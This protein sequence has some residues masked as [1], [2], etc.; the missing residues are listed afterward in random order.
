MKKKL[1]KG[2]KKTLK[3]EIKTGSGCVQLL[4]GGC[5]GTSQLKWVCGSGAAETTGT[6]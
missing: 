3:V 6:A 4:E 1:P 5:H 2:E